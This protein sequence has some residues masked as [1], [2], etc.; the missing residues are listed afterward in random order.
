MGRVAARSKARGGSGRRAAIM[1]EAESA[2]ALCDHRLMV[3]RSLVLLLA[4]AGLFGLAAL[5]LGHLP[6]AWDPRAPLD[7]GAPPNALTGWKLARL[8]GRPEACLAAFAASGVGVAPVADRRSEVGCA[9]ENAVR[10]PARLRMLPSEPAATCPLAAAWF[11]FERDT[12]QPA[13]LR[14]FGVPVRAARHFGTYACRNL[15]HRPTGRRSEH[16]TANAID[17][18]GFVLADGREVSLARHWSDG[19][20]AEAAFL[21]EV[22]DGACRWFRAVLGPEHN[23]EH[24]DHFHLDRGLWNA[25]R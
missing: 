5:G 4:L 7:L 2:A 6:P 19:A 22:R 24:R 25:C 16:A 20:G 12:L 11:L 18:A 13:A 23:A 1:A 3:A 21:R 10:L 9:I 14:H 8:Q 17:V 15:N